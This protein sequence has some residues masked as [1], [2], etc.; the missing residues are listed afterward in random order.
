[1]GGVS[2]FTTTDTRSHPDHVNRQ[3]DRLQLSA[4]QRDMALQTE[5]SRWVLH[6]YTSKKRLNQTSHCKRHRYIS[7]IHS[8]LD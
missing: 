4:Q 6:S 8:A 3:W 7:D 2:V 1:M 5:I